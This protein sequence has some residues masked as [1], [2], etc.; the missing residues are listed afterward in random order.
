MRLT[1]LGATG[2]TGR[3]VVQQA[4]ASGHKVTAVVRDPARL[5]LAAP[6]PEIVTADVLDP[7]ALE[8]AL[9]GSETVISCL[10]ARTKAD[11]GF[12]ASSHLS[13]IE[14]MREAGV[15]RLMA[16]SAAPVAPP[17]DPGEG[18][19]TR[20]IIKPMMRAIL[21][22]VYADLEA[23]EEHIRS[24]GLDWTIMRPPRLTHKPRTGRYRTGINRQVRGGSSISRADLADSML[25]AAADPN[26][27]ATTIGIAY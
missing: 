12:A 16:I 20:L 19:G 10:G 8:P 24:S 23:M 14:A 11:A 3:H 9:A 4:V 26:T 7:N 1:V 6:D 2:G 5:D 25:A 21:R 13:V 17:G 15:S 22:P 18:P 27:I